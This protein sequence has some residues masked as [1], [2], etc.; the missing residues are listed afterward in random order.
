MVKLTAL[1]G[2][3][4]WDALELHVLKINSNVITDNALVSLGVVVSF[5]NNSFSFIMI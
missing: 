2:M 3:M 1:M 5:E 4:R